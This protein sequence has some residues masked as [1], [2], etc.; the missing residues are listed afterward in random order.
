MSAGHAVHTCWR[1]WEC[2]GAL[3]AS[4]LEL[5]V[6]EREGAERGSHGHHNPSTLCD[7]SEACAALPTHGGHGR[8][9]RRAGAAVGERAGLVGSLGAHVGDA[10]HPPGIAG[11]EG[12]LKGIIP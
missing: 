11:G 1:P 12:G 6:G 4:F 7:F 8:C 3:G 5:E 2:I 10:H 9:V